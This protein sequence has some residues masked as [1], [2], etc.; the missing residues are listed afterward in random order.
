MEFKDHL[1]CVS[2]YKILSQE[3]SISVPD[4]KH[5]EYYTDKSASIDSKKKAILYGPFKNTT[6]QTELRIHYELPKPLIHFPKVEKKIVLSH[7][8]NI[9]VLEHF[10]LIN[11][12]AGLEGE[13]SRINYN[14]LTQQNRAAH[15]L[16]K[17]PTQLPRK[18]FGLYYRDIIGNISTSSASREVIFYWRK[19]VVTICVF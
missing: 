7:L 15:I 5:L 4:E 18:A 10:E 13:F 9:E 2:P 11:E 14:H 8:G 3:T 12:A 16:R 1:L 17:I 19:Y 6:E